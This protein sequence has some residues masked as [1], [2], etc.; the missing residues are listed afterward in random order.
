MTAFTQ[1]LAIISDVHGCYKTLMAL[2]AKIPATHQVVLNGDMIDRGPDSAGVVKWAMDNNVPCTMGNHEDLMLGHFHPVFSC[3]PE[4]LGYWLVN[5][6]GMALESWKGD[7][8]IEVLEWVDQLP[9]GLH[10]KYGDNVFDISHTGYGNCEL[11][12]RTDRLWLRFGSEIEQLPN[13]KSFFVFGH[14]Q[15]K[16]PWIEKDFAM[17]DTGCAYKERGLGKLT[18][19]L[20]PEKQIIQQDNIE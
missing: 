14:T 15:K 10:A 18:A 13:K 3:C 2:V 1:P 11:E 7:I 5:G 6:G 16:E 12:S 8:P 4:G 20:I 17:I 9:F 19:F